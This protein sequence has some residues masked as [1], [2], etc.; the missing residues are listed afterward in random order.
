MKQSF[1]LVLLT[2]VTGLAYKLTSSKNRIMSYFTFI[3]KKVA[4]NFNKKIFVHEHNMFKHIQGKNVVKY[5]GVLINNNLSWTNHVDYIVLKISIA[6]G[7]I[8]R[9]RHFLLANVLLN[10]Y[11][12][13]IQQFMVFQCFSS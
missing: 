13:L 9:L 11:R 10:I 3:N 8:S 7:I 4:S 12:S 2:F 1:N 6:V 5:F